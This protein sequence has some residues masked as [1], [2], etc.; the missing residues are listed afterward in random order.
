MRN[1][2]LFSKCDRSATGTSARE[3]SHPG[4][5]LTVT[6]NRRLTFRIDAAER[7]IYDVNLE[8]YH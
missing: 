6:R 1:N 5:V 7:K 3:T 8:N 2:I 4:S